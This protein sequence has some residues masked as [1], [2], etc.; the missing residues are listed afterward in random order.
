MTLR[1]IVDSITSVEQFVEHYLESRDGRKIVRYENIA[2]EFRLGPLVRFLEDDGDCDSE[3]AYSVVSSCYSASMSYWTRS[4][5]LSLMRALID[6]PRSKC[7]VT[8][9]CVEVVQ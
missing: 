5:V 8:K 4:C 1:R 7:V 2:V 9:N 3:Y 6:N